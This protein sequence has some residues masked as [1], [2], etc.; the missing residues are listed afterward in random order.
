MLLPHALLQLFL[1]CAPSVGPLTMSALVVYESAGRPYA[2]ADDSTHRSYFP[3]SRSQAQAIAHRL[4]LAGHRVDV[5]YGQVDSD[6]F[7]RLGIN[8]DNAFE[9]CLNVA[10]S[11]RIL[12]E[13]YGRAIR[14]YRPRQLALLHALSAYNSGGYW[15][16]MAY[17]RGVYA[18]AAALQFETPR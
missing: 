14:L 3:N 10:A 9:P 8:D 13:A 4:L 2:I 12:S 17:A 7:A 6:N 15:A 5:G 18:T 16:G 11:A 1:R